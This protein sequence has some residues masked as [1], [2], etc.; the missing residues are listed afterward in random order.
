MHDHFLHLRIKRR[1]P[2]CG[3]P[4]GPIADSVAIGFDGRKL[5]ERCMDPLSLTI[6]FDAKS[7]AERSMLASEVTRVVRRADANAK[8]ARE[9]GRGTMDGGTTI[10]VI[11]AAHA[12]VQLCKGLADC[13]R[14]W[15]SSKLT[16][17]TKGGEIKLEGLTAR[18]ANRLASE[19][20]GLLTKVALTTPSIGGTAKTSKA[21]AV[22][23]KGQ[24]KPKPTKEAGA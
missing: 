4:R 13:L 20:L 9:S 21:T 11:I 6:S 12:T 10:V 16:I 15:R 2:A 22:S 1:R 18:D 8:I 19:G 7:D 23:K 5:E 24:K 14:K 3:A 17:K